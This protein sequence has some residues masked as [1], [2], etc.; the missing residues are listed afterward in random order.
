MPETCGF[1]SRVAEVTSVGVATVID[2]GPLVSVVTIFYNA[3]KPFFEEAIAS[4]LSQTYTHWE[5]LLVDDGSTDVST[6]IAQQ[7]AQ[8]YPEQIRYFEHADHQNRGMSTSRNLGIQHARGEYIALLDADDVWLSEKLARQVEVLESHP[9][10]GMVYSAT[11]M[12]HSW[13]GVPDDQHLDRARNL[14]VQ[15]GRLVQ[16]PEL[17]ILALQHRAETPATCG[18][19]IR[20]QVVAD[21]H[22]FV[23]AFR[24]M[25]EDQAFFSKVFLTTAVF[26]ERGCWD[27]YRQ[28]PR[29]SCVVA[30]AHGLYHP[31]KANSGEL[32]FLNWLDAHLRERCDTHASVRQA[33]T[34]AR[35]PYRHPRLYRWSQRYLFLREYMKARVV[36]LLRQ[37]IPAALRNRLQSNRRPDVGRV[38]FGHL[39]RL[40]PVSREFGFDRGLPIDRYYIE[41]FLARRSGDIHGRALEIGD[42]AYTRRFGGDRVSRSD[43]L[44]VKEGNPAATIVGDLTNADNIPSNTFDCLILT[45]TL[46]LIFDLRVALATINRILKP[47]GVALVTFPGI[48]QIA[49]D[50]WKDYWCW[51]L[52]AISA[53][54][55]FAE[56]FPMANLQVDVY[57][58]V[59]AATSFLQGLAAQELRPE[60][61]DHFD[62][63]YP[64]LITVRAIK[65]AVGE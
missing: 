26:I 36:S 53:R 20:R 55:L 49:I 5:L 23:D 54:K 6:S 41:N 39:R 28:H 57:G 18:V 7:Y 27:Y 44:H 52:T 48:S 63:S 37:V 16:A 29:G 25:Y 51:S 9:E 2:G 30:E 14:G 17:L 31:L 62:P 13:T 32:H 42:N 65:P 61:L 46:H 3:G 40:T 8:R 11:L 10:A 59:L 38:R 15:P 19:L 33:L 56:A 34:S 47:G 1:A 12:W 21:V 43:V 4:V 64:V 45:Q 22:G 58:N 24:G 35:F 50:E 60:E